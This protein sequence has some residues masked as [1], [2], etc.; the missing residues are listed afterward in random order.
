[1][2]IDALSK[3]SWLAKM[4][5]NRLSK[6]DERTFHKTY[7]Y[8]WRITA[9]LQAFHKV[10]FEGRLEWGYASQPLTKSTKS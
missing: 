8:N 5:Y 4:Y 7:C 9:Q 1:M 2:D 6:I 10:R 3:W